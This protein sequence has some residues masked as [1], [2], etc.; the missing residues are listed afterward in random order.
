LFGLSFTEILLL[1]AIGLIVLGPQQMQQVARVLGKTI[2]E[3]KKAMN[4]VKT[5]VQIDLQEEEYQRQLRRDNPGAHPEPAQ[6]TQQVASAGATANE[7]SAAK[8][9]DKKAGS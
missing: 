2:G 9:A 5:S 7:P 4:E 3:L 1:A 8:P 6:K